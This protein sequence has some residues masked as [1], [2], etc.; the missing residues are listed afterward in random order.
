MSRSINVHYEGK[1][2][3]EIAI[4]PDFGKLAEKLQNLGYRKEQK[5]CVITDSH[6]EPMYLESLKKEL[7][8][9][10][11]T[12]CS[13]T[14]T[15]GEEQKNV[16]TVS[17]I[18]Q[19]LIEAHFD[20]KDVLAALG[21]GVAGDI[22]GFAAATYLRGIDFIQIPT[23]LL[24]QVDSSIGGK[25]GV[26]FLQYKNMVGAFYQPRLVYMNLGTLQSLHDDHFHAGMGEILKHGLIKDAGYFSWLKQ[27]REPILRKDPETLEEMIARSCEIKRAVVEKDPK[28]KGDRALL[29]F[30]HTVGHAVEKISSFQ[31]IHGFCVSIGIAAACEISRQRGLLSLEETSDILQ[32]LRSFGLP[33]NTDI[34]SAERVLEITKSDKKM[35]SGKIKFILLRRPG[36]AFID[37]TVTDDELL[38]AIR[39]VRK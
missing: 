2:C 13:F 3:Y 30:G 15:A 16:E 12:V 24:S 34:P 26:D 32:T 14:F 23:T 29:N 7:R 33:V 38:A 1:P 11:N 5:I 17:H 35:E 25:T 36:E 4:E 9:C 22:C 8:K 18:Y 27:N 31:L 28:E 6:V 37:R 10:F 20:R 39:S 19:R 21:G